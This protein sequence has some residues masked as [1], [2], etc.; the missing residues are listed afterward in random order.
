MQTFFVILFEG[1]ST[2]VDERLVSTTRP[3]PR[4]PRRAWRE[5]AKKEWDG[6]DRLD[7]VRVEAVAKLGDAS[8]DLVE[9]ASREPRR[10]EGSAREKGGR[11]AGREPGLK[12]VMWKVQEERIGNDGESLERAKDGK[13]NSRDALFAAIS[14]VD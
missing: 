4:A 5:R 10:R 13:V 1:R 12:N 2:S 7:K 14:L 11:A 9:P 8:G 3:C 6:L